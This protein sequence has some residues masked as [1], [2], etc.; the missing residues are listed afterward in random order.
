MKK[1]IQIA[2]LALA[3]SPLMAWAQQ[4][5]STPEQAASALVDAVSHKDDNK[6]DK[7]FVF[8]KIIN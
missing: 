1:Q 5:F 7:L 8:F 6:L 2:L 4:T 3:M